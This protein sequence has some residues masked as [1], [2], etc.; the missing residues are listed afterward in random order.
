LSPKFSPST[1]FQEGQVERIFVLIAA[2]ALHTG[3]EELKDPMGLTQWP[4]EGRNATS[5]ADRGE[6]DRRLLGSLAGNTREEKT[7]MTIVNLLK[8]LIKKWFRLVVLLLKKGR[9][10]KQT[11]SSGAKFFRG[12]YINKVEHVLGQKN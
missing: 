5:G 1:L 8:F 12:S 6:R 10:I 2:G 11:G 4:M 3:G 9:L 7:C